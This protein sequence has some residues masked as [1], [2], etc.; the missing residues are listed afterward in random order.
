MK[1][2]EWTVDQGIFISFCKRLVKILIIQI[3]NSS[4]LTEIINNKS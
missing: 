2:Y 3:K 4:N 1:N